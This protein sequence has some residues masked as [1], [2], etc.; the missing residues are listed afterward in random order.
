MRRKASHEH[1]RM[2]RTNR[3]ILRDVN[4]DCRSVQLLMPGLQ[5]AVTGT[6]VLYFYNSSILYSTP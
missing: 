2:L 3:T 4:P 1:R 5:M 6:G